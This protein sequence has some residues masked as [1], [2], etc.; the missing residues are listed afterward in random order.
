MPV[1]AVS[2]GLVVMWSSG[3]IGAELG[4]REA[5]TA[6]LLMWR[7]AVA[8]ILL[9]SWQLV[10]RR[11]R[12]RPAMSRR[13]I[14]EQAVVGLLSQGGYLGSIVWAIGLGVPVGTTAL[15]ASLQPLAAA[16]LAGRL[17]GERITR[18]RV[19]GLLV[20]L[21]GVAIVVS[22]DLTT[23]DGVPA[24]AYLLPFAGMASLLAASFAE[25]RTTAR[26]SVAD[27]LPVHCSVSVVLFVTI[28]ATTGQTTPPA[29]GE[30]WFAVGWTVLLST[31]GGY[32]FYWLSITANG[33]IRTSALM[34]L[35]PPTTAVWAY[36]MFGTELSPAAIA[37]M[38]ICLAGVLAA[39]IQPT[40]SL[41]RRARVRS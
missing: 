29:G 18:Q 19:V 39:T 37:G 36:V 24:A 25:R 38:A 26:V 7:F 15:I 9:G 1:I 40:P 22:G 21:T 31:I 10:R 3:F 27:A 8:A 17:V 4:T 12:R 16:M 6:T 13:A 32:G 14:G 5:G 2:A 11:I 35:T 28:A 34:Y 20:G 33:I 41:R 23:A 30:F